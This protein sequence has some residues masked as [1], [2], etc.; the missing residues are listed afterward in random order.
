MEHWLP[1]F[2]ERLDTLFDYVPG[3]PMVLEPQVEEAA[4]ER[5]DQIADYYRGAPG[6]RIGPA[7]ASGA[8]YK[9]LPPE[10]L[11]LAEAEWHERLDRA[12][13]A[14]L[15]P[16]AAPDGTADSDRDRRPGRP[17]FRAGAREPATPTC[18]RR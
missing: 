1:L 16:F 8:P 9:P 15:S 13:L 3:A 14:R 18:S 2:H 12:A 4:H 10:R 6:T 17:Q 11:Y 7:P 5:R